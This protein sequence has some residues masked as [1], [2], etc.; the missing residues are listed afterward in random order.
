[1]QMNKIYKKKS[2]DDLE[3]DWSS[4]IIFSS[5]GKYYLFGCSNF[6]VKVVD[7]INNKIVRELF[8]LRK[9]I[10]CI[11]ISDDGKLI[12]A[13]GRYNEIIIWDF[14]SGNIIK[15]LNGHQYSVT[16]LRFDLQN[17]LLFSGSLDHTIRI[18]EIE[19]EVTKKVYQF[20]NS[21]YC[22]ELIEDQNM[23]IAGGFSTELIFIDLNKRYSNES[24]Y[25]HDHTIRSINISKNK[26]YFIAGGGASRLILYNL[27]DKKPIR[28]IFYLY[29][30]NPNVPQNIFLVQGVYISSDE[31][32]IIG[33]LKEGKICIWD[34]NCG[35]LKLLFNIN[36]SVS[37]LAISPDSKT[38]V[39]GMS[40]GKIEVI[41]VLYNQTANT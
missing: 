3:F 6:S 33:V 39:L 31:N 21:I 7:K 29:P 38:F 40:F 25:F 5:D 36:E 28:E 14:E 17:K 4:Q 13:A 34:L 32:E 19:K 20:K 1:M 2:F 27:K 41:S 22:L 16:C 12:S 35:K 10:L 37:K 18:W 11:A 8:G 15:R 23:L 30:K 24:I 26:N 9:S